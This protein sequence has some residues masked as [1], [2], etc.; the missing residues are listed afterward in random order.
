MMTGVNTIT[1]RQPQFGWTRKNPPQYEIKLTRQDV[2]DLDQGLASDE[3]VKRVADQL[4]GKEDSSPR[5]AVLTGVKQLFPTE[6]AARQF[7]HHLS[8]QVLKYLKDTHDWFDTPI[9]QPGNKLGKALDSL[10]SYPAYAYRALKRRSNYLETRE[11]VTENEYGFHEKTRSMNGMKSVHFTH[12]D[13]D[14]GLLS[15]MYGPFANIDGGFPKVSDI[16]Q[17]V[18]DKGKK[19]VRRNIPFLTPVLKKNKQKVLDDYTLEIPVDAKNDRPIF[20]TLNR[21]DDWTGI[22]H[23]VSDISVRDESQE[24]F[25]KL[26]YKEVTL[27][28]NKLNTWC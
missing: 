6:E 14:D 25:R 11:P 2:A 3:L 21:R 20:L 16:R 9:R 26:Q 23:G 1:A 7:H 27:E 22:A 17:F 13:Y 5:F 12:F 18:R 8:N 15:L 4:V 19:S 28:P 24:A 10:M